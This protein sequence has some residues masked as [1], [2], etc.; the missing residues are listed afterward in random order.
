MVGY[1]YEAVGHSDLASQFFRET[2]YRRV[3]LLPFTISAMFHVKHIERTI[4]ET[5]V[6]YLSSS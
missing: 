3:G 6:F 5:Y 2:A 1:A 4:V